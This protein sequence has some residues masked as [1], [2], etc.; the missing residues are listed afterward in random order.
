MNYYV[1]VRNW[2]NADEKF[3]TL[4]GNLTEMISKHRDFYQVE[5]INPVYGNMAT[6]GDVQK[7]KFIQLYD[8]DLFRMLIDATAIYLADEVTHELLCLAVTYDKRELFAQLSEE[9]TSDTDL[10]HEVFRQVCRMERSDFSRIAATEW[11][12][13]VC[14]KVRGTM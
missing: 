4:N 10:F 11:G 6:R 12:R 7:C 9:I 14:H 8:K 13:Y 5:A 1:S 2:E 3:I